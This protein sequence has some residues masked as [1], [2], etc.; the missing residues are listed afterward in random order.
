MSTRK[1]PVNLDH[2]RTK[3]QREVMEEIERGQFCPFCRDRWQENVQPIIRE[4]GGWFLAEN[5]WPYAG[6]ERHLLF[7]P[8][9]HVEHVDEITDQELADLWSLIRWSSSKFAVSAGGLFIR[10]GETSMTGASVTHLHAHIVVPR[11][12]DD[13]EFKEVR[14]RLSARDPKRK[15]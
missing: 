11:Q 13:P 4:N 9:R 3:E 14:P 12:P 15:R 1:T 10:F 5:R 8:Q 7:I 2:A 6:T